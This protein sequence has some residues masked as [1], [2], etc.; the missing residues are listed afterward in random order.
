M[1]ERG[2]FIPPNGIHL[3]TK[4]CWDEIHT[5]DRIYDFIGYSAISLGHLEL[6][7]VWV[8]IPEVVTTQGTVA[9]YELTY[10]SELPLRELRKLVN[11]P[12][13]HERV[14]VVRCNFIDRWVLFNGH[15][16]YTAMLQKGFKGFW[17][18]QPNDD[19]YRYKM[20]NWAK[21]N[22]VRWDK[23]LPQ[24][25]DIDPLTGVLNF[26]ILTT[27]EQKGVSNVA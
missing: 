21:R 27:S 16:R 11:H 2:S 26:G 18:V 15:H 7:R 13:Y 24:R 17:A 9:Q 12:D 10:M 4:K 5:A 14:I 20:D 6:E 23:P 3:H 25:E 22:L 19:W 1:T 8:R